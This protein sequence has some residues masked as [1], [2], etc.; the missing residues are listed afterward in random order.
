M[1]Y[2]VNNTRGQIIAVVQDGTVNTTAT[3][4]SL[5][6]KNVTPY[7]E[8]EVENLVH[9]LENFANATPPGNPIEGQLWYNSTS[10]ILNV[11][12]VGATGN[13]WA[14]V[15]GMTVTSSEPALN[16]KVGDLWYNP[17]T[18]TTSIYSAI[19]SGSGWIPLNTVTVAN[20]APSGTVA[21]ELYFNSSSKQLFAYD[22]TG[23]DL[24]G[25]EGIQG[26]ATTRWES[27][28]LPDV[29]LTLRPVIIGSVNGTVIAIVSNLAFT[30]NA[31]SAPAGFSSLA[32]GINMASTAVLSG[33]ATSA[34][35]LATPRT[36]NGVSFDGTANITIANNGELL[37]GA[38]ITGAPY[39]GA[40]QQTWDVNASSTNV[41]NTVVARNSSGNFSAGTITATLNGNA[42]G[43]AGNVTGG[44]VAEANGG[45]GKS[46]YAVGE[47]L[48]G[49]GSGL[50]KANITGNLPI[51][52]TSTASGIFIDYAGGTG[53]GNVTSVGIDTVGAG[54]GI[55]GSPITS[56][57]NITIRNTGVTNLANG[58]G[59]GVNQTNGN[60]TVT[61]TGVTGLTNGNG[62]QISGATGNIT[63]TNSGVTRIIPG[64]GVSISP[65]S[66]VG[67]VIISAS[68]GGNGTGGAGS[69]IQVATGAGLTGGPITS[70]GTIAVDASVMRSNVAQT[71]TSLK[72]FTGGIV[73]QAYNFTS[74]G[75]SI[76]WLG[77]ATGSQLNQVQ[78]AVNNAVPLQVFQ[79][80]IVV[81]GNADQ[82]NS[83]DG[84]AG[85]IVGVDNGVNGG[86]GVLGWHA[87]AEPGLGVG[88]SGYASNMSFTGAV[89]QG[90][91]ARA[92]SESFIQIRSY[93]GNDPVFQVTGGGNVTADG[94]YTSPAADYA[95]YFEWAD[96]NPNNE[97]RVGSSV[98]LQGNQIRLAQIGD[99][100]IGVI[101]A[102]PAVV[103][104]AAELNWNNKYLQ[105][106]FGRELREE[107]FHWEWVDEN[108]QIQSVA[109]YDDT[110]DVPSQAVKKT[111]D[112]HGNLLTCPVLNPAYDPSV[113][114]TPRSQRKEWAPVGLIGKLRVR[115]GQPTA[116]GWI[117][118]RDISQTVEEWLVK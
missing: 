46:S 2:V 36:I 107:Y 38:Y 42:T 75:N 81:Q 10:D 118:L 41:A 57:G 23:W 89:F 62:I 96:G 31:S 79:T 5:V 18:Y 92:K 105:D 52:V 103:G 100:V 17:D 19:P 61:N 110:S 87:G 24:I 69:V 70:S 68:G 8:Y 101:S 66:G 26:F 13:S 33:V 16:P 56:A 90:S 21:G 106:E 95:E 58:A 113:T 82:L 115:V 29:G 20:S 25:P 6:G 83:S 114:Y 78:I 9:Q 35:A 99:S 51:S 97:D 37:A 50:N 112:G 28:T 15:S 45:T 111:T 27:T 60:V 91:T 86:A 65:S 11:F 63:V 59:I 48:I 55:T 14:P 76:Y 88:T 22:G 4:Q 54:I 116:P 34:Q 84:F 49:N 108:G 53:T 71:I 72:A 117:K 67:E 77:P 85:A 7:G 30:I 32:V 47:I 73:S 3:S 104:D 1:A 39:S 94:T 93:S 12:T 109:S 74:T 44:V 98:T 102:T 40:V 64:S 80:K 43:S